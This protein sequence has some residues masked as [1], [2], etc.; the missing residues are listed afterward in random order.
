MAK[1]DVKVPD[2]GDFSDVPVI[3]VLVKPGDVVKAEQSLVTL[4]SDKAAMDVPSP[5]AGTVA[6]VRGEGRRQS[7]DG[8]ADRTHRLR[9]ERKGRSRSRQ[10]RHASGARAGEGRCRIL[11]GGRC[12]DPKGRIAGARE[13]RDHRHHNPR[14]RRLQGR[15]GHRDSGEGRRHGRGG[16]A[17]RDARIRQGEH[18]RAVTCGRQD[19]RDCRQGRRQGVDGLG[20]G[21]ARVQRTSGAGFVGS[22]RRGGCKGRRGRRR[23]TRHFARWAK[24]FA[25]PAAKGWGGPGAPRFL[26]RF[27]WTRGSAAGARAWPRSQS[28]EGDGR[29]RPHHPRG[30]EGRAR[31]G[32][33]GASS[34]RRRRAARGSAGRLRQIRSD[35]DRPALAHQEDLGPAAACLVGQHSSRHPYRRS[36][37]H[38][39]RRLPK[40]SR[41]RR[42]ERQ[43]KALPRLVA[44]ASHASGGR[45]R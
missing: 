8:D 4:E 44:A 13:G 17:D 38:R 25:A 22:G 9:R 41:R 31:Q 32:H 16:A 28:V 42:E 39:S 12:A 24:R 2:I 27:R 5:V 1:V 29:E 20:G 3:E 26:G 6:E 7:V 15:A 11:K 37:H 30:R 45:R 33:G 36:G 43:I 10:G 23:S 40:G 18:G 34:Q 14:H 19:H 35:R 21:E